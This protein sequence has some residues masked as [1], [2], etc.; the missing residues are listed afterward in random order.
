MASEVTVER[1]DL[2]TVL[3]QRGQWYRL[4]HTMVYN[5]VV[6]YNAVTRHQTVYRKTAVLRIAD[7]QSEPHNVQR[8]KT[9]PGTA[10]EAR[11]H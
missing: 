2:N 11:G 1:R 4:V 5:V 8:E 6:L 7:H 3:G 9:R 10:G